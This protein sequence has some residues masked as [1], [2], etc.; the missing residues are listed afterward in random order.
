MKA[1]TE[2][3][4]LLRFKNIHWISKVY[5]KRIYTKSYELSMLSVFIDTLDLAWNLKIKSRTRNK[6]GFPHK[7]CAHYHIMTKVC[8][9][10]ING[11]YAFR[12]PLCILVR[13]N[14]VNQ[15]SEH[16][17]RGLSAWQL[18]CLIIHDLWC[19]AHWTPNDLFGFN[20]LKVMRTWFDLERVKYLEV[21]CWFID[22][23]LYVFLINY[24]HNVLSLWN[25]AHWK[26]NDLDLPFQFHQRSTV[27]R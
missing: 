23:F 21:N 6:T 10:H 11:N 17:T 25:I 22:D 19:T 18:R 26:P 2:N 15:S 20:F 16:K 12:P 7:W 14:C 27:I 5:Q 3:I 13:L 24:G 8:M 4:F 9:K 1:Q